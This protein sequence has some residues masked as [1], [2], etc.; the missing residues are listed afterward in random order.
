MGLTDCDFLPTDWVLSMF[1]PQRRKA[2]SGYCQYMDG[3]PV[4]DKDDRILGDNQFLERVSRET[5]TTIIQRELNDIVTAYCKAYGI[6]ETDLR[7]PSR[8]RK[9]ARIRALIA[10]QARLKRVR[11]L[12]PRS[13]EDLTAAMRPYPK[14]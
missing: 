1:S 4:M 12:W 10:D 7:A 2:L 9:H 13:H 11:P 8:Y 14:P 5:A 6:T 3:G